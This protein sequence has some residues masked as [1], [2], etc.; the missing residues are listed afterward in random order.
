MVVEA[1]DFS[2]WQ[3]DQ[4]GSG[5]VAGISF[6]PKEHNP[7]K[8]MS[9]KWKNWNLGWEDGNGVQSKVPKG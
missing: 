9:L 4:Y 7:H 8:R 5:W 3:S 2:D 1:E 6:V